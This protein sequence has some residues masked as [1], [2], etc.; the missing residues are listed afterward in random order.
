MTQLQIDSAVA[1]ATGE[2]PRLIHSRG[3]SLM[4]RDRDPRRPEP[5]ELVVPCPHCGRFVPYPGPA[6]DGSPVLAECPDCDACFG[7]DPWDVS[8]QP[9]EA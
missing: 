6:A 9:A 2:S 4:A 3:F 8:V 1:A 7:F 5:L